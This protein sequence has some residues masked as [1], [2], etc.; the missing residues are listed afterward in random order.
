[1]LTL[2]VQTIVSARIEHTSARIEHTSTRIEHALLVLDNEQRVRLSRVENM[3]ARLLI[4]TPI[5]FGRADEFKVSVRSQTS[6]CLV[7]ATSCILPV[8]R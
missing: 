8:A 7:Y 4:D 6:S 2:N 3:V 1:M 5:D